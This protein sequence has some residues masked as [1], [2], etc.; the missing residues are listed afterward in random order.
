VQ[1]LAVTDA[2][3]H[4]MSADTIL[5]R[6]LEVLS[7]TFAS[8]RISI[9]MR[10]ESDQRF[11]VV[12]S[13]NSDTVGQVIDSVHPLVEMMGASGDPI[14]VA[15]A[16]ATEDL[17][18]AAGDASLAITHAVLCV[19]IRSSGQLMGFIILSEALHH[20][21]YGSDDCDL[22]K[23]IAHHVGVLLAHARLAE[24]RQALAELE[25]LHRFSVFCM[26]DLKNL[27]ARLSLVAQNAQRHGSNPE[28]QESA[29][30]TVADTSQKMALLMS[31]LSQKSVGPAPAGTPEPIDL[32][33]LI[34]EVV[35]P[36]RSE[37]SLRLHVTGQLSRSVMGVREQIQQV[38]LNVVLNAK[39]AIDRD[40]DISIGLA[41]KDGLATVTVEDTGRG[42]PPA[43]LETLFRPAQSS[44]P[45]GLGVGLYQCRQIV[46][47]HRGTIQIRSEA[48]K[49]TKVMIELPLSPIAEHSEVVKCEM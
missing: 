5:D 27:A 33:K 36:L 47:A 49:G 11:H 28:F 17:R 13:I 22:L 34:H 2:F 35:D 48:G 41:E 10:Y 1:W 29:M 40:G 32:A 4:A 42:I 24:E 30:R 7:H 38:L 18:P 46:E 16:L 26:H 31:K 21:R 45:G 25:A 15:E 23:G 19:P 9:W 14:D 20:E 8:D 43:M 3:E 37:R 44:R 12:R 39:Q 6:L